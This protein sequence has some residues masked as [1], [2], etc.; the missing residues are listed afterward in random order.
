MTMSRKKDE[1][2][3]SFAHEVNGRTVF[4]MGADYIPE[5][6][7]LGRKSSRREPGSFWRTASW[8]ITTA[9]GCGEEQIYPDDLVL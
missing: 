9:F 1:Q 4:A 7:L 5:D 6:H 8:P 3:E 2:G